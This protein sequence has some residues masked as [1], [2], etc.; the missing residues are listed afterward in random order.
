M[1]EKNY[2][3]TDIQKGLKNNEFALAEIFNSYISKIKKENPK[4]NAYLS[5]FN[6]VNGSLA[7]ARPVETKSLYGVPCA[8]KDNMLLEGTIATAG[9]KILENYISAYDA[10]AVRKLKESGALFLGKTNLDEFAMGSSTENSAFGPTKNPLD[11][12][13]VPGGSSGGSAAAVAADLCVFALGSDTGGSIRQPAAFC[14]VVG[15]KPTYG[16]VS[17]SGLIAMASSLDQIGPITKNVY[18]AA[19][20]L[21]AVAGQDPYDSTTAPVQTPDF[22]HGLTDNIRGLRVGVPKE[23]FGSGLDG[24]VA[25]KVKQAIARLEDMGAKIIDISLPHAEYS[26]AAYYIVMP[27]EVSANLARFDGIRYGHSSKNSDNLSD[28][29][30]NS[31]AEGFGAEPKRRIM[32]G[33]YALSSGYYDA[34]YLKAQKVRAV[35]K[36][37]FNKAFAKVDVIAG[38]TTPTVAFKIGEKSDNPL[39]MYLSDIYTVPVNLAGLP[40]IS[41]PCGIGKNSG[42]PVGFQIIGRMFDEKTV[43]HVA[44]QLENA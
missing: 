38:P 5:T 22:T 36:Q 24:E 15:L 3:I 25:E 34:Y 31:R 35:I 29:Y 14:G 44:Y 28:V 16:R 18:D 40:A 11:T 32:L 7:G 27:C 33:T 13:R 42:L 8:I 10:T 43:L 21:N 39:S 30:L 41:V 17:R 37:D 1:G 26:L 19:L 4:L 23:F 9:S 12:S 20:I 6:M 2:T